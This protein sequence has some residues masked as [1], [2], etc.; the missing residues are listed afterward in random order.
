M[1]VLAKHADNITCFYPLNVLLCCKIETNI[2]WVSPCY[3]AR[4]MA[5]HV[6]CLA[7]HL[8]VVGSIHLSE[9]QFPCGYSECDH[10]A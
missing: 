7:C 3:Q 5:F 8:S 10:D 1:E 9:T 6:S 4:Y 2:D